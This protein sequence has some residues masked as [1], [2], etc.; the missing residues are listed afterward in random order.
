MDLI[1]LVD[2]VFQMLFFFM[3]AM[4]VMTQVKAKSVAMAQVVGGE[5]KGSLGGGG[6]KAHFLILE[7]AGTLSLDGAP[8]AK[9]A[10]DDK[11]KEIAAEDGAT[12]HLAMEQEGQGDR[13]PAVFDLYQRI[14]AAGIPNVTFTKLE[15]IGAGGDDAKKRP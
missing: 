4:T 8:V 6:G 12:L 7:G 1:P 3:I 14:G 10:L 9:E 15:G 11:L 13:G 2:V 5:S